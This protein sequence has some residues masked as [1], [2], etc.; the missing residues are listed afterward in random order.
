MKPHKIIVSVK[1]AFRCRLA[2]ESRL[3]VYVF[4]NILSQI[5]TAV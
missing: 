2:R 3:D 4:E 5:V 1:Q